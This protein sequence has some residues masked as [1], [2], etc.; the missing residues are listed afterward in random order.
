[1]SDAVVLKT[2]KVFNNKLLARR[3][4]VLEIAHPT[5]SGVSRKEIRAQLVKLYKVK[6]PDTIIVHGIKTLYGGGVSAGF[7]FIYDNVESLKRFEPGFRIA[8]NGHDWK[9]VHENTT[10]KQRKEKKNKR[11]ITIGTAA[12]AAKRQARK[13]D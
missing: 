1:M 3:Q 5:Q 10:R 2:K 12:R 7:A 4:M 13:K 9:P 11:K 6:N 8:K